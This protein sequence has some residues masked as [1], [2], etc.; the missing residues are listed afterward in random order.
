MIKTASAKRGNAD[1][2][3]GGKTYTHVCRL[4]YPL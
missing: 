1:R 3:D 4:G 2:D